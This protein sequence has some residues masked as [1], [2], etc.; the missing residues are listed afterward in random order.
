MSTKQIEVSILGQPYRLARSCESD[1]APLEACAPV[2]GAMSQIRPNR[3]GRGTARIAA[4]VARAL[5]PPL[6][7]MD[8]DAARR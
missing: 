6:V 3:P 7:W 4:M 2:D 5:E 1:A 8:T